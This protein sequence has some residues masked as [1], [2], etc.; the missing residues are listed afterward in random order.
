MPETQTYE[1]MK[2]PMVQLNAWWSLHDPS[3]EQ[4]RVH[5]EKL[6]RS[7]GALANLHKFGA[8]LKWAD[9]RPY[10]TCHY[11]RKYFDPEGDYGTNG[12]LMLAH[13]FIWASSTSSAQLTSRTCTSKLRRSTGSP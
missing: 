9:T 1:Q 6:L 7:G 10:N 5:L 11:N 12:A 8:F 4:M 2:A 3:D 13:G